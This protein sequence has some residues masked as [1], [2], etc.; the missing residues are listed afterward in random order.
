MNVLKVLLGV[1]VV[2]IIGAVLAGGCAYSGYRHTIALDENVQSA[3]SDIEVQLER[4]FDLVPN[5]VETVKGY[6][7]HEKELFENL[8]R[9]REKY[10]AAGSRSEKMVAAGGLEAALSRLLVLR[11]TYPDL[12]ANENFRGLM[13]QL[14]G[15]ENRIAER[16]RRY[17]E[18][19][20]ALNGYIRAF[21]GSFYASLAGVEKADYFKMKEG[22]EQTPQVQFD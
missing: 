8:A 7:K 18:A 13:I 15:T 14:E 12:K 19:V 3:W 21:P 10:F 20:E 5:L 9:S 4:R 17:N 2:L 1:I 22:A 16:R 6:A 11:E